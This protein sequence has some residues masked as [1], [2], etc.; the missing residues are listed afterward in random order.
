M[1]FAF[2][3]CFDFQRKRSKKKK[4]IHMKPTEKAKVVRSAESLK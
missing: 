3:I 1:F 2:E 4:K